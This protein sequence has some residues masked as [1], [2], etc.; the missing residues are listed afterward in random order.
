MNKTDSY[1][2]DIAAPNAGAMIESLRAF[3]YDLPTSIS[4]LIDNSITAGAKNVW[5]KFFWN[6][7]N[8]TISIKDDGCGMNEKDLINAM[9]PGSRSPLEE[10]EPGSWQI[11]PRPENRLF[12]PMQETHSSNKISK[13]EDSHSLLGYRSSCKNGRMATI[14]NYRKKCR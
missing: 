7:E 4:D 1:D 2:F 11:W 8:S 9:R 14:E 12:F 6:G 13:I 10:R 5:L 3:G